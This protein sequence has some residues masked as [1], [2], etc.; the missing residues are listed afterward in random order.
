MFPVTFSFLFRSFEEENN[1]LQKC[2]S[3]AI[4][5]ENLANQECIGMYLAESVLITGERRID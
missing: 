4:K 5:A 2:L 3:G 1:T